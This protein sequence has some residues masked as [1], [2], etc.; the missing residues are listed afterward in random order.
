MTSYNDD[1]V[2]RYTLPSDSNYKID[3]MERIIESFKR[4]I[5]THHGWQPQEVEL[6][7]ST[8]GT[9]WKKGKLKIH[10][11]FIPNDSFENNNY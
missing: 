2:I 10:V 8:N 5:V 3:T 7:S 11:T 1:D 6:L 9:G 4:A